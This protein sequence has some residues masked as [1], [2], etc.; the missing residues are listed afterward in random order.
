MPAREFSCSKCP[1]KSKSRILVQRHE[2]VSHL[3][4]KFFRCLKCSYVTNVRARYT[5]HVRYHSMP[6]IK[7]ESCNFSTPYKSNLE[8]HRRNHLGTVA[9]PDGAEVFRCCRCSFWTLSKQSLSVHLLNHHAD[10]GG[11]RRRR[12]MEETPATDSTGSPPPLAPSKDKAESNDKCKAEKESDDGGDHEEPSEEELADEDDDDDDDED[13]EDKEAVADDGDGMAKPYACV[14]CGEV[15]STVQQLDRHVYEYHE[16]EPQPPPKPPAV[17]AATTSSQ[18]PVAAKKSESKPKVKCDLCP[19]E[20]KWISE[21]VRHRRVHAHEKPYSCPHCEF[22]SRWKGD[23]SRHIIKYHG[24][25]EANAVTAATSPVEVKVKVEDRT[26]DMAGEVDSIEQFLDQSMMVGEE[27]HIYNDRSTPGS[28]PEQDIPL[29]LSR[30]LGLDFG[31]GSGSGGLLQGYNK[32]RVPSTGLLPFLLRMPLR[33]PSSSS[34]VSSQGITAPIHLSPSVQLIPTTA[35]ASPS[36]RNAFVPTSYTT[37]SPVPSSKTH[38]TGTVAA[39]LLSRSQL[40]LPRGTAITPRTVS[41]SSSAP[42]LTKMPPSRTPLTSSLSL[43]MPLL[44]PVT[45]EPR[46]DHTPG[47]PIIRKKYQCPY[48]SYA[49]T[50]ASRFHMHIVVH[51]NQKPYMCTECGYRSNWQWDITK[52]A[53]MKAPRDPRHNNA[54]VVVVNDTGSKNYEKYEKYAVYETINPKKQRLV[55]PI[56]GVASSKTPFATTTAVTSSQESAPVLQRQPVAPPIRPAL[57]VK[58][59]PPKRVTY[60]CKYCEFRHTMRRTIVRHM[61]VHSSNKPY[62]C[63]VCGQSSNCRNIILRHCQVRHGV[64]GPIMQR[65]MDSNSTNPSM[66]GPPGVDGELGFEIEEGGP[67]EI[68]KREASSLA[69]SQTLSSPTKDLL[70]KEGGDGSGPLN[71]VDD[72]DEKKR[73]KCPICPY[74]C[75]KLFDLRIHSYMHK[76]HEG[77]LFKCLFCPFYV[78][79]KRSWLQHMKLHVEQPQDYVKQHLDEGAEGGSSE[80]R[81]EDENQGGATERQTGGDAATSPT[82]KLNDASKLRAPRPKRYVC[83]HCPY[84]T[85]SHTTFLY[86]RQFHRPGRSGA[87]KCNMCSY[88]VSKLHLLG[89]HIR[90]HEMV[91]NSDSFADDDGLKTEQQQQQQRSLP[92]PEPLLS[93][94]NL[95]AATTPSE[96]ELASPPAG[97]TQRVWVHRDGIF[98]KMF[99]CRHCPHVSK[100]KSV[101][102]G[103]EKLHFKRKPT[104]GKTTFNCQYCNYACK[105]A[106]ILTSHLKVHRQQDPMQVYINESDFASETNRT[107][108]PVAAVVAAVA[109]AN[110]NGNNSKLALVREQLRLK[111]PVVTPEA[112]DVENSEKWYKRE[113]SFPHKQYFSCGLCPAKFMKPHQV[114]LHRTFHSANLPWRCEYCT[115]SARHRPH[116]HNHLRAHTADYQNEFVKD[117]RECVPPTKKIKG[118]ANGTT[119]AVGGGGGF[120]NNNNA[121]CSFAVPS[122]SPL[123]PNAPSPKVVPVAKVTGASS[124]PTAMAAAVASPQVRLETKKHSCPLCPASFIKYSTL[125]YHLHLHESNS[126]YKCPHCTYSVANVGNLVRHSKVHNNPEVSKAGCDG[127]A[128]SR[129]LTSLP[130]AEGDAVQVGTTTNVRGKSPMAAALSCPKCPAAFD[131]QSR[132]DLHM[133]LHGSKQR[134]QCDRC[135]Y[136]VQYAANLVRHR[137]MHAA[138]EEEKA[139]AAAASA[140]TSTPATSVVESLPTEGYTSASTITNSF[141]L[142]GG[143]VLENAAGKSIADDDDACESSVPLFPKRSAAS[144]ALNTFEESTDDIRPVEKQHVLLQRMKQYQS[145]KKSASQPSNCASAATSA[146][147]TG[148]EPKKVFRCE[149]CPY[150]HQRKDTVQSH[151]K[152]HVLPSNDSMCPH[153]DYGSSLASFLKEHIKLHFKPFRFHQVDAFAQWEEFE[154][155]ARFGDV[156]TLIYRCTMDGHEFT[157]DDIIEMNQKEQQKRSRPDCTNTDEPALAAVAQTGENV[158]NDATNADSGLSESVV[159]VVEPSED[160]KQTVEELVTKVEEIISVYL[161]SDM[162]AIFNAERSG[163]SRWRDEPDA[164][165]K[166]VNGFR[167]PDRKRPL[168][169]DT[170]AEDTEDDDGQPERADDSDIDQS[171]M[172]QKSKLVIDEQMDEDVSSWRRGEGIRS[173][174]NSDTEESGPTSAPATLVGPEDHGVSVSSRT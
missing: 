116:L 164:E 2:N 100:K 66:A 155:W 50:T 25:E 4:K 104:A 49:T 36:P 23:M 170:D 56:L 119:K 3:K 172:L 138:A 130:D 92:A 168:Q 39:T 33:R 58:P 60:K 107:T 120:D 171:C 38:K 57:A 21:V 32:D 156:K 109:S 10:G 103:H 41:V 13:Q 165:E 29:D 75:R 152:R 101:I 131:K 149:R 70:S 153:C 11:Q 71:D 167:E 79:L 125:V 162:T 110:N 84:R 114:V 132:F 74:R 55:P 112:K 154:I 1:F 37:V 93:P 148:S 94:N 54:S 6:Y 122:V 135:D 63:G 99:K 40:L 12:R 31:H 160:V 115:Y 20:A 124:A 137:R 30:P 143:T 18:K 147:A 64:P 144:D 150:A 129:A 5:K 106:G 108:H 44:T 65:E 145:S 80:N 95:A 140:A 27:L 51:L 77:A 126:K 83:E 102:L 98:L 161:G 133:S 87:F 48:C 88:S 46:D 68:G 128:S 151:M 17:A 117:C 76:P 62:W 43:T 85:S 139:A 24:E 35:N 127:E 118:E 45:A 89:Q 72:E 8:R 158:T 96:G 159:E 111:G 22:S 19:Y 169:E 14:E 67:E 173:L 26:K 47:S 34:S 15:F 61:S 146:S 16:T 142:N 121:G 52:H 105:N 42:R 166:M 78:S 163:E 81:K 7:C 157:E 73:H 9:A 59:R 136:A 90:M 28:A 123:Q 97:T 141:A 91:Q 69:M 82:S 134:F 174:E 53:K 113:S 86:H